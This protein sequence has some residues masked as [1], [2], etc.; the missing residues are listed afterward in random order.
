MKLWF[1]IKESLR[2]YKA[3]RLSFLLTV[4][5]TFISLCVL[6][7]FAY[8][9]LNAHLL[10]RQIENR[11]EI[12]AFLD[13]TL[14]GEQCLEIF[15]DIKTYKEV[16]SVKFISKEEARK[17]FIQETGIDFQ[18]I[19]SNN[20]L[21]ASILIELDSRYKNMETTTR[22]INV[23]KNIDGVTE[24]IFNQELLTSVQNRASLFQ[25]IL[26]ITFFLVTLATISLI[27]NTIKLNLY[28]RIDDIKT[29][30]LV[31]AMPYFIRL[32]FIFE[33]II[34]G[35]LGGFFAAMAILALDYGLAHF[36]VFNVL[37]SDQYLIMLCLAIIIFGIV[38]GYIGSRFSIR[39]FFKKTELFV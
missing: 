4:F 35:F 18:S 27:A 15:N 7:I 38:F 24:V 12:E 10:V 29:M 30:R 1:L 39:K 8:L 20:P 37:L 31:G 13:D 16:S 14:S 11:I 33:G 17:R 34:V 22:F 32:P 2:G 25:K 5:T 26:L 21:P 36:V 9:F 19:I 23:L 6:G 28:N 3:S